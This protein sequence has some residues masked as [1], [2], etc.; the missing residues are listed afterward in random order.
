MVFN[1]QE[2]ALRGRPSLKFAVKKLSRNSE[3]LFSRLNYKVQKA[4]HQR[5]LP[6]LSVS[7]RAIVR[8]LEHEGVYVTS[9]D[10]LGIPGSDRLLK[11]ART[12]MQTISPTLSPD[13]DN[14]WYVGNYANQLGTID[15]ASRYPDIYL[16]GIQQRLVTIIG[17]YIQQP[18]AYLATNLRRDIAN[19]KQV[20]TRIWHRDSEDWRMLKVIIYLNDTDDE[21]G[22]FEYI[23]KSLTPADGAFDHAGPLMDSTMQ[24]IIPQSLWKSCTGAAGTVIFVDTAAVFHHGKVPQTERYSLFFTY[25]SKRPLWLEPYQQFFNTENA[26]ILTQ[27]LTRQQ[28]QHILW[29]A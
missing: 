11:A 26:Q 5:T 21:G 29:R 13:P 24:Q 19:G 14:E 2:K 9:L 27:H 1:L 12:A 15:M 28:K 18:V 17:H 16:W 22:P 4:V 6:A 23:P 7:E 3:A 8:G 10:A 25:T 20:G